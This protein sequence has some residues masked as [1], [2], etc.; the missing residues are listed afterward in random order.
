MELQGTGKA[1]ISMVNLLLPITHPVDHITGEYKTTNIVNKIHTVNK[2]WFEQ[3]KPLEH[4]NIKTVT[5]LKQNI[6]VQAEERL[7]QFFFLKSKT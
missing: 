5:V 2:S 7:N 3:R 4:C 6:H 1:K